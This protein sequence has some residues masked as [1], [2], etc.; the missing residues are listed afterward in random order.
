MLFARALLAFLVLPGMVAFAIP[1]WIAG[2]PFRRPEFSAAAAAG[3]VPFAI[4][5]AVLV[6]CV[7]DFYVAGRG[8]L[9]P[10]DPPKHLVTVGL[11]R[12]SRNP[13]YVG[14]I[15][16]LIGWTAMFRLP[17][18]AV[19][20]AGVFVL[21]HLRVLVHEEPFL[22]RTHGDEWQRYRSRVPRWLGRVAR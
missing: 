7:R 20:A 22:K 18:L 4:G 13:I 1:A 2:V 16:I 8:T 17:V 5:V 6:W 15:L 10:W 9:A 19:Y 14:V 3:A 12:W 21:F 11:Y